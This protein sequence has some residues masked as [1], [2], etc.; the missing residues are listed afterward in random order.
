MKCITC[1]K[2]CDKQRSTIRNGVVIKG[3]DTCLASQ[4]QQGDSAK[5]YREAQKREFRRELTQPW[6]KEFAQAYPD[7][8]RQEWGDY[9]FRKHA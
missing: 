5:F 3:C 7:Q 9:L 4:I 2:P 8:A 1:L 6:Q